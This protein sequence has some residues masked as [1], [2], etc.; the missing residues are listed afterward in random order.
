[1][2]TSTDGTSWRPAGAITHDLAGV[3]AVQAASGPGGYVIAGTVAGAGGASL[4]GH[5]VVARPD[6]LDQGA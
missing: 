5:L 1:M 3:S 2:L 4:A 6:Q